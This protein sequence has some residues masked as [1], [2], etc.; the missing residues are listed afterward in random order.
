MLV[1]PCFKRTFCWL[2]IVFP[3]GVSEA[4][5]EFEG[6][7]KPLYCCYF[8]CKSMWFLF[9]IFF[10]AD[11]GWLPGQ[12]GGKLLLLR[13]GMLFVFTKTQG[14]AGFWEVS[15]PGALRRESHSASW[16]ALQPSSSQDVFLEVLHQPGIW[17]AASQE[18]AFSGLQLGK[19]PPIEL[20][21]GP[22]PRSF[23]GSV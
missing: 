12:C 22:N 11:L 20:G 19:S 9:C 16:A 5:N 7:K 1:H 15:S 6:G 21:R 13:R 2:L 14:L 10:H 17:D 23:R 8:C 18:G 4:E 3:S